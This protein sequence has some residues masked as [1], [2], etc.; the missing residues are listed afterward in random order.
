MRAA[1]NQFTGE[2]TYPQSCRNQ[3]GGG[4]ATKIKTAEPSLCPWTLAS[5]LP[6]LLDWQS[7]L[8]PTPVIID[9]ISKHRGHLS[10]LSCPL[11]LFKTP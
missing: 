7:G 3:G 2:T 11:Q 8:T 10:L 1:R 6:L 4:E 5:M 9:L